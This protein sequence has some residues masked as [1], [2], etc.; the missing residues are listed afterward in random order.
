MKQAVIFFLMLSIYIVLSSCTEDNPNELNYAT[1]EGRV[2]DA[3]TNE[4]LENVELFTTPAT[5]VN[6]SSKTGY[7]QFKDV[8]PGN[9]QVTATKFGY[10]PKT[11]EVFIQ[12]GKMTKSDIV[13]E[14][15]GSQIVDPEEPDIDFDDKIV[16]H[17]EF[18]SNAQDS[19]PNQKHGISS[20]VSY[21]N[22]RKGNS[23]SAIQ[24][25]GSSNSSLEVPNVSTFNLSEFTYSCWLK[26][27]SNYGTAYNGF[28]DFI[29]R[30]GH[31]GE[32]AQ[33]FA[34]SLGS[35]GKIKGMMYELRNIDWA[36]PS[37]YTFFETSQSVPAGTWSH[38]ALTYKSNQLTI[39][40]DGEVIL[41]TFSVKPQS[42][43]MYGLT[44]GKRPDDNQRS[45]YAGEMDDLRLYNVALNAN[46]IKKLFKL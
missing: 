28:I 32:S 30:W 23:N 15:L 44:I 2:T 34:F 33:S 25:S 27:K 18:N 43:Q 31:W 41:N 21:T 29:S 20:G 11:V 22:D 40:L 7:Y 8:V 24:F 6:V 10:K 45:Y 9:Y 36:H 46:Q 26:P 13:L 38:I 5:S 35:S 19:G 17:Y 14:K 39:Y 12:S 3:E 16:V 4:P 37:N 1:I 42:S